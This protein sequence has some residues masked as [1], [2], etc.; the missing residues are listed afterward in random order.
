MVSLALRM[1]PVWSSPAVERRRASLSPLRV[2][3][4]PSS[5]L[6]PP[7]FN[8]DSAEERKAWVFFRAA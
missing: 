4:V 1:V 8:R 6:G 3:R 7:R 2:W 5:R